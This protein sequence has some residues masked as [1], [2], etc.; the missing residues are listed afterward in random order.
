MFKHTPGSARLAPSTGPA[1]VDIDGNSTPLVTG[2]CAGRR[3]TKKAPGQEVLHVALLAAGQAGRVRYQAE[4][5]SC[6]PHQRAV[7]GAELGQG[8]L[9]PP[10]Q[11][12][13][14]RSRL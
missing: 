11:L 13:V 6:G 9:A 14:A 10:V 8:G 1:R 7:A 5:V 2:P 4:T 3:V 12:T